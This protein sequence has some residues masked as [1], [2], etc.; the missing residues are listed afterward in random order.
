LNELKLKLIGVLQDVGTDNFDL[1][2]NMG[3]VEQGQLDIVLRIHVA[4]HQLVPIPHPRQIK[5]AN[6]D[7]LLHMILSHL[8]GED[9]EPLDWEE[10]HSADDEQIAV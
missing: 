2:R 6:A 8:D 3:H 1:D 9:T 5:D 10:H 4:H 7:M